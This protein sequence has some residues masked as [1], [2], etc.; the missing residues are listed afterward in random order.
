[1]INV[2]VKYH[3]VIR[4]VTKEPAAS[5]ELLEGGTVRDLLELMHRRYG[6]GFAERVLDDRIGVRSYV[7]LFLNGRQLD[8]DSLDTTRVS[9]E[10]SSAEA[11]LYVMSG[12]CGGCDAAV[13]LPPNGCW[14]H[15]GSVR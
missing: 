9:G 8:H 3:G 14:R 12:A 10:G 13:V 7:L 1:M 6:P 15:V 5:F 4:D 2:H 11:I